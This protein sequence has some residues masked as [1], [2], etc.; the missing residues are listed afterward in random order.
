MPDWGGLLAG[1]LP[2]GT[3]DVPTTLVPR[4][5]TDPRDPLRTRSRIS[6]YSLLYSIG[7]TSGSTGAGS[8]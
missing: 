6:A 4:V 1:G 2:E 3:S 7:L 8:L 5:R